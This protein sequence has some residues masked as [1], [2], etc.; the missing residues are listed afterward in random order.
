MKR[1]AVA[2]R[3]LVIGGCLLLAG[4]GSPAIETGPGVRAGYAWDT[5]YARLDYPIGEVYHAAGAAVKELHLK[6]LR[7]GR[8][9]VAGEISAMDAQHEYI[10]ID[11]QAWPRSRT[12]LTIRAGVFGDRN[13]SAVIFERILEDLGEGP[14]TARSIR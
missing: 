6:V 12:A 5:L 9:G 13:K 14:A 8:D 11:L 1:R 10:W 7:H 3:A 4:C 2:I